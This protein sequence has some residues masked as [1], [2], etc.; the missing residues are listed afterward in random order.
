MKTVAGSKGKRGKPMSTIRAR[1]NRG[2]LVPL[3]KIALPEG[4]EVTITISGISTAEDVE[5][6]RRSAGTWKGSVDP[7]KLIRNLEEDAAIGSGCQ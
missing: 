6:F 1:V 3:E 2:L 5:A 4:K 7:E